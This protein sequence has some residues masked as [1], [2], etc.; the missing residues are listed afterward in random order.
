[1]TDKNKQAKFLSSAAFLIFVNL[2]VKPFWIFAIDRKV[3]NTVGEAQ[4]GEYFALFNYTFLF[5]VLLDFGINSFNSR[6]IAQNQN[7]LNDYFPNMLIVKS[8][9]SI[10]YLAL[11]FFFA[12]FQTFQTSWLLLMCINQILISFILYFR[13]NLQ[14]LHH[15]R[16]DSFISILDRLLMIFICA[17]LLYGS[18]TTQVFRIEYFIYAQTFA[19][20]IAF[21][22]SFI[23]V[24]RELKTLH[25]SFNTKLFLPIL[26]KTYP[27]ALLGL[28]MSLYNRIDAV[29][30]KYLLGEAGNAEAGIYAAAYRLLD[31]LNMVAVLLATILLP[32]FA[33]MFQKGEDVQPLLALGAKI[34]FVGATV[35]AVSCFFF[36]MPLMEL[37]YEEAT[38][39]YATIF[40]Y[41]ILSFIAISSVYVYGTLLTAKGSLKILNLI[42]LAGV[43]VNIS[44]NYYFIPIY[45]ALGATQVTFVTQ[46]VVALAHIFATHKVLNI[47]FRWHTIFQ[48]IAFFVACCSVAFF[49][50]QIPFLLWQYA[51]SLSLILC[52]IVAILFR[53]LD[54]KSLINLA[55]SIR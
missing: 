30:I 41:L 50:E 29:M 44:L 21:V 16:T 9:L 39:Y 46:I 12:Q 7:A 17:A 32:M 54:I 35:G 55:K 14:G 33:R 8:G 40:A 42:A 45:K 19:Y 47:S 34:V 6:A 24:A 38:P 3:Q 20:S 37:L 15:F 51:F 13:S 49:V 27:F 22:S 10:V 26:K 48:L 18:F 31:A 28:L 43:V 52:S 2:I 4:Y 53:L 36:K 25:F 1:M 5:Y 23:L 11:C